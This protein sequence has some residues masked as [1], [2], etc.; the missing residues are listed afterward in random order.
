MAKTSH[1]TKPDDLPVGSVVKLKRKKNVLGPEVSSVSKPLTQIHYFRNITTRL[2]VFT[3]IAAT[4][5]IVGVTGLGI[6]LLGWQ[7]PVSGVVSAIV[8]FPAGSINGSILS[9]HQYYKNVKMQNASN[10]VLSKNGQQLVPEESIN[11]QSI[12]SLE[13]NALI[14]KWASQHSISVTQGE[15]ETG[16]KA[17][18]ASQGGEKLFL[19]NLKSQYDMSRRDFA[20]ST[21]DT[22]LQQK[23]EIAMAADTSNHQLFVKKVNDVLQLAVSGKNFDDLAATYSQHPTRLMTG[24]EGLVDIT[25]LPPKVGKYV[26]TLKD[27]DINPQAIETSGSF[28]IVKRVA[29]D[30]GSEARIIMLSPKSILQWVSEQSASAKISIWLSQAR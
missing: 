25:A 14:S 1:T 11:M 20:K 12:A 24:E 22:L 28:Y 15:T 7:N 18:F 6:Y 8:P 9:Y 3:T 27:G 16:V 10:A 5:I 21:H 13:K 29:T 17:V 19:Q 23:V 4:L 2:V 30:N 26:L